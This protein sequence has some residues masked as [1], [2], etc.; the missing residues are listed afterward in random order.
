M[1][2]FPAWVD[3][4]NYN[5]NLFCI[6]TFV[7]KKSPERKKTVSWVV[8]GGERVFELELFFK[9]RFFVVLIAVLLR[10]KLVRESFNSHFNFVKIAAQTLVDV[11]V[12]QRILERELVAVQID[13]DDLK[14]ESETA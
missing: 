10:L 2:Q 14:Y 4:K 1:V 12:F 8:S 13:D 9:L 3:L 11:V 6:W 5:L 7:R